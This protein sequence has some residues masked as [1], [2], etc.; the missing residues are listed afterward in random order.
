MLEV[1]QKVNV[2]PPFAEA[3]PHTSEV[4]E[5]HQHED[6]Q[7]AYSLVCPNQGEIGAFAPEYVEAVE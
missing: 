7:V 4:V 6:G 5:V 2:L 3:F 1:G